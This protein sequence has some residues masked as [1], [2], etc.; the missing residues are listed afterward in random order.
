MELL[1]EMGGTPPEGLAGGGAVQG[2]AAGG[3]VDDANSPTGDFDP[4]RID[5]M[6]S[7][8]YAMNTV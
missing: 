1:R 8:L 6:V 2:Y 4:A 3:L 7:D 5:A